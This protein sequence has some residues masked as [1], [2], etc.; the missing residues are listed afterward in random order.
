MPTYL[1]PRIP[2]S[3]HTDA[4][5]SGMRNDLGRSTLFNT[6]PSIQAQDL[7]PY[8]RIRGGSRTDLLPE[9]TLPM[10]R[11]RLGFPDF[12]EARPD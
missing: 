12:R 10:T 11:Y 1:R 9:F 8:R 3:D 4:Q 6:E 7:A 2:K 5:K